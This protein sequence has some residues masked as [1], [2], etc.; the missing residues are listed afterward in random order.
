MKRL[1]GSDEAVKYNQNGVLHFED[2][3]VE[4]LAFG[5]YHCWDKRK[6]NHADRE[7]SDRNT[8]EDRVK[9]Q[10]VLQL[11]DVL[12]T[13]SIEVLEYDLVFVD[14]HGD[15]EAQEQ[16]VE[17]VYEEGYDDLIL[18]VREIIKFKVLLTI[19]TIKDVENDLEEG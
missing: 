2:E 8:S 1:D 14:E 9:T 19:Q 15:Q 17:N 4:P 10:I 6:E 5:Q 13:Q 11:D 7:E 16:D 18:W 3:V 12:S